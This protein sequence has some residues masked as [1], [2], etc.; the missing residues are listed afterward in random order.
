MPRSFRPEFTIPDLSGVVLPSLPPVP[1]MIEEAEA[2]YLYWLTSQ[3]YK[4]A[5][6]VVEV[7]TCLGR[8]SLHLAA[9][10]RDAGY[11]DA[12]YCFDQ[13]VWRRSHATKAP[14]PLRRGENFQPFFESNVR[15][16]YPN[17]HVTKTAIQSLTWSGG[18]IEI[19][20]L[21]APKSLPD[22]SS[23]LAAFGP[24]L[25]PGVS[26]VV[27]QDY[28]HV[29]S[30]AVP[31]VLSCLEDDLEARHVLESGSAASFGVRKRLR[32]D[33]AQPVHWNFNGWSR[34]E[35]TAA[36]RRILDPVPQR[37]RSRMQG[38]LALTLYA[39]HGR[40]VACQALREVEHSDELLATW[41]RF[42]TFPFYDRF[43]PLFRILGIRPRPGDR[44]LF[45]SLRW[46]IRK[47]RSSIRP[48][49]RRVKLRAGGADPSSR[50]RSP[51]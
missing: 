50:R 45:A 43:R 34:E 28:M 48:L 11:H 3:T 33:T 30:F 35:T 49:R 42:T 38:G 15:P 12:L 22:L 16:V 7:G 6:A 18:A 36:W 27:F 29:P 44:P 2:R 25:I 19:L 21:D 51:A 14:L 39:T 10:L 41:Q 46:K 13:F 37:G 23:V 9:G 8:S 5:G 40:A 31:L 4:G 1:G 26:V 24:S 20:F 32:F 47:V 17:L